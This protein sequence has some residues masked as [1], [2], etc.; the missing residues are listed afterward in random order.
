MEENNKKTEEFEF[1]IRM[2][3]INLEGD[4]KSNKQLEK[5]FKEVIEIFSEN[6]NDFNLFS[7]V[8]R[9]IRSFDKYGYEKSNDFKVN[10]FGI[11]ACE[12][13]EKLF[14]L[15]N[16]LGTEKLCQLIS[17]YINDI[18]LKSNSDFFVK[19]NDFVVLNSIEDRR[20]TGQIFLIFVDKKNPKFEKSLQLRQNFGSYLSEEQAFINSILLD[21]ADDSTKTRFY[22]FDGY[23]VEFADI[24]KYT[25]VD[26]YQLYRYISEIITMNNAARFAQFHM[27]LVIDHIF[28]NPINQL[29][30]H[31]R[32]LPTND[33]DEEINE[34]INKLSLDNIIKRLELD[35]SQKGLNTLYNIYTLY[36]I[37]NSED[38]VVNTLLE[39]DQEFTNNIF[40]IV[41]GL[42]NIDIN[43]IDETIKKIKEGE[44]YF[45][46][47]ITFLV[48]VKSETKSADERSICQKLFDVRRK[49][50]SLSKVNNNCKSPFILY[51]LVQDV[52]NKKLQTRYKGTDIYIL[53]K[54]ISPDKE[55]T[56][57]VTYKL[58]DISST[59][60]DHNASRD[61]EVVPRNNSDFSDEFW[62]RMTRYDLPG[63]YDE[64]EED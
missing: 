25:S 46:E 55:D 4:K 56:F 6:N 35:F 20:R 27:K 48:N 28:V 61:A 53:I 51:V 63:F 42:A 58:V 60:A 16:E 40:S 29:G 54:D 2:K 5:Y 62:K 15:Y 43:I 47:D 14:D 26:K 22:K 24:M 57:K 10:V 50:E 21:V 11:P 33:Q 7:F 30:I 44:K 31:Y 1:P 64:L 19:V 17:S 9:H 37:H 23:T 36:N 45:D 13:S 38:P 32:I 59:Y 3:S 8:S 18:E 12:A 41:T 34:M 49:Y 52:V 39:V